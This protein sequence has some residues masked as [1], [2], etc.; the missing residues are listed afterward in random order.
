[1]PMMWRAAVKCSTAAGRCLPCGQPGRC[2]SSRAGPEGPHQ[3]RPAPAPAGHSG[4][5][6]HQSI[7]TGAAHFPALHLP[8]R[9]HRCVQPC[10]VGLVTLLH[11]LQCYP[12]C[13]IK[14]LC[15]VAAP[16]AGSART[17]GVLLSIH[18][19]NMLG[20]EWQGRTDL[21]Q[22]FFL[23]S[24]IVGDKMRFSIVDSVLATADLLRELNRAM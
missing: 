9:V 22:K 12:F 14:G 11:V 19:S 6:P 16:S 15:N 24:L 21:I 20:L 5:A 1:M 18:C 3:L 7:A 4:L 2:C 23:C 13:R 17:A 10:A 8:Y